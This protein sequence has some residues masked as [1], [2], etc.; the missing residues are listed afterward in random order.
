MT[1]VDLGWLVRGFLAHR[2]RVLILAALSAMAGG[3]GLPLLLHFDD[4]LYTATL[5]LLPDDQW[6]NIAR[7]GREMLPSHFQKS[8]ATEYEQIFSQP[9]LAEN[10]AADPLMRE[11][12][13][14]NAVA[15]DAPLSDKTCRLPRLLRRPEGQGLQGGEWLRVHLPWMS[16]LSIV[17]FSGSKDQRH[18]LLELSVIGGSQERAEGMARLLYRHSSLL[19]HDRLSESITD[20]RK[21]M[22]TQRRL[23]MTQEEQTFW[24][25]GMRKLDILNDLLVRRSGYTIPLLGD[26]V[27]GMRIWPPGAIVVV[28]GTLA[29]IALAISGFGLFLL[30]AGRREE[31]DIDDPGA[32]E[33]YSH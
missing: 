9:V 14:L 6:Q 21:S 26:G 30:C 5:D 13:C 2:W 4:P 27:S 20:M 18:L 1:I 23:S 16:K 19:M 22:S 24:T 32:L 7:I 8:L 33:K 31:L 28:A 15:P 25:S 12:L 11:Y 17:Y 29:G 3:L 10:L